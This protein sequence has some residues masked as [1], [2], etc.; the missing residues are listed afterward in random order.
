M[1]TK[2]IVGLSFVLLTL[3]LIN[4]FT[5][6]YLEQPQKNNK[7]I[8]EGKFNL[9]PTASQKATATNTSK[10]TKTIPPKKLSVEERFL[11]ADLVDIHQLESSIK[12]E[13]RYASENNFMG[14]K[15]YEECDKCYLQLEAAQ[16]LGKAQEYLKEHH[17]QFNLKVL[18][19]ARPKSVQK[20]MWQAV[21][22]TENQHYVAAPHI[23]SMH[24]YGAA[25]DL[26]IVDAGGQELD[27]GAPYDHFGVLSAPRYDKE[28][29]ESGQ[30]SE[31]QFA[32]RVLLR[33]IMQRAGFQAIQS[34][35]WHFL[36]FDKDKI[37]HT[38]KIIK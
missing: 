13:I 18:D 6:Q 4:I 11:A 36:A 8:S 35:W 3:L 16:K 26:T 33:N 28:H 38:Y 37:K 9:S 31:T 34:E 24:N 19:C 5:Y 1:K 20:L 7:L 27:M 12:V 10:L 23:G 15:L 22:D 32:N 25:I 30:L 2:S 29:L 21:K 17:P 14:Q